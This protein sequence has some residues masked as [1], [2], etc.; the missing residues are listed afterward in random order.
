MR[1]IAFAL[2][3]AATGLVASPALAGDARIAWNDLDLTTESGKAELNRRIDLAAQELCA[4]RT[5]TGSIIARKAPA[6]CLE[7][8]RSL[9]AAKIEAKT[10]KSSQFAAASPAGGAAAPEA[11][12]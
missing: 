10:D 12:R 6:S 3:L 5:V 9:I 7:E 2:A 1:N 11:R 8:A 4:P